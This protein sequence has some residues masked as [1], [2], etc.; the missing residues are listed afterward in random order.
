MAKTPYKSRT[1]TL[2]KCL[3]DAYK[4][5]TLG[6]QDAQTVGSTD[7][8]RVND[9][10]NSQKLGEGIISA[11][12]GDDLILQVNLLNNRGFSKLGFGDN[13]GIATSGG[14]RNVVYNGALVI[15]TM[16]V[17]RA[18]TAEEWAQHPIKGSTPTHMYAVD[19]KTVVPMIGAPVAAI[20]T[21]Q[22]LK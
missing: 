16:N 4:I 5:I 3:Q 14:N 7:T 20:P 1:C 9:M 22:S 8:T 17:F 21:L 15:V 18:P 6:W 19:G 10:S 13:V 12:D 2:T 11:V